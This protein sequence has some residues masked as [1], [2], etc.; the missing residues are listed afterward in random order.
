MGQQ[1]SVILVEV[2][3]GGRRR[4][5]SGVIVALALLLAGAAGVLWLGGRNPAGGAVR[6]KSPDGVAAAYGYPL[7]CLSVTILATDRMYAR[8]DFNHLS[9]CGRYTWYP[10]AIFHYASGRR[11]TVLDAVNYVCPVASLP[12]PVQTEL[13]VCDLAEVSRRAG[14]IRRDARQGR[15]RRWQPRG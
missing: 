3:A 1:P 11:R 7:T 6:E 4:T 5:R 10:T 12:R 13:G 14:E 9:R 15:R 2:T 8:A